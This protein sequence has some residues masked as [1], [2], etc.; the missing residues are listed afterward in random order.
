[1]P[2][3]ELHAVGLKLPTFWPEQSKVW[4]AQAEAQ[5][6][7]RNIT[8]DDT[9][10]NYVVAALD[11]STAKRVIDLLSAPPGNAKYQAL[12]DRLDDTYSLSEFERGVRLLHMP[13]QG[14][15]KPSLLM[16]NMLALLDGHAP[17]F[18][19]RCLFL[20]RLPEDIRSVLA[21][22][23]VTDC[24]QL[25]KA[26]DTLWEARQPTAHAVSSHK[27]TTP[28]NKKIS[29]DVCWYHRKFG[30]QAKNCNSPCSFRPSGN[31]QAGCQ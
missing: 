1:M 10:F 20:E 22:S 17:C 28:S 30:D 4:F 25:A 24:R 9:K 29:S 31:G 8:T 5:F 26:A 2:G 13:E 21:H 23:K 3:D 6:A 15:D 12:K 27:G 14:D 19:F 11:Q 16:D 18:I 7:L